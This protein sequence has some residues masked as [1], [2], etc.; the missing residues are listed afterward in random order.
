ME[1]ASALTDYQKVGERITAAV[2][3]LMA[4]FERAVST[5]IAP[6]PPARR[7][8]TPAA[9][10]RRAPA[11]RQPTDG[12]SS[13]GRCER[14]ILTVLA[15]HGRRTTTQ[16]ALLSG[17]S[18]KSGGFRN[19]L[20]SLRSAGRIEGRGDVEATQAG[21]AALGEYEP[22]PAGPALV[23][24]WYAQLGRAERTVLEVLVKAWPSAVPM[25]QIASYTGYSA[26]S[27]GFR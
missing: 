9:A 17:Y 20:S 7:V 5:P 2:D 16:V 6:S 4:G 18:A 23:E 8:E 14:A 12:E 21:V 13:L 15:Q 25:D 10:P 27:G 19:S 22:L 11:R 3:R 26:S 24:W 1:L